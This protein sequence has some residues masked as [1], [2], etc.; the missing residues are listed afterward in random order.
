MKK[1]V[2]FRKSKREGEKGE[3]LMQRPICVSNMLAESDTMKTSSIDNQRF[4]ER[5]GEDENAGYKRRVH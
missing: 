3:S 1:F 5:T 4:G 2:N